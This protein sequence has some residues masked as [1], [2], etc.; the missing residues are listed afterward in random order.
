ME[1]TTPYR[2]GEI[3]RTSGY[4]HYY[5]RLKNGTDVETFNK[6][7]V[8]G[9]EQFILSEQGVKIRVTDTK[10]IYRI[11]GGTIVIGQPMEGCWLFQIIN[12]SIKAFNF[13]GEDKAIVFLKKTD[14][15]MVPFSPEALQFLSDDVAKVDEL[16]FRQ[17]YWKAIK[18]YNEQF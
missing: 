16:I 14:G 17:N 9:C 18:K 3:R 6:I 12:G 8:T 10:W 2:P 1:L 11:D 5:I 15:P 13:N 7:D 4:H